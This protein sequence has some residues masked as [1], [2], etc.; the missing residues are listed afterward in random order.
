MKSIT[1]YPICKI[2]TAI[3]LAALLILLVGVSTAQAQSPIY[4]EVDRTSLSTDET[5]TL[6]VTIA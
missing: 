1:Q 3:L 5:L 6:K 4:A 2:L